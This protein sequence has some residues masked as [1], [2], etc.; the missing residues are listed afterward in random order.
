MAGTDLNGVFKSVDFGNEWITSSNG[1]NA[2]TV[3]SISIDDSLIYVGTNSGV[4]ICNKYLESWVLHNEGKLLTNVNSICYN[5]SI[6]IASIFY[7]ANISPKN[8]VNWVSTGCTV[9]PKSF[10]MLDNNI[11]AAGT[12]GISLSNNNGSSWT[13][14]NNGITNPF[15]NSITTDGLNLFAGATLYASAGIFS[16][17]MFRSID[18]GNTW[19]NVSCGYDTVINSVAINVDKLYAG[20]KKYGVSISSDYGDSWHHSNDISIQDNPITDFAFHDSIVFISTEKNGVYMSNDYGNTWIS[21]NNGLVPA[22]ILSLESGSGTLYAG[23]D[24]AGVW[25]CSIYELLDINS[26]LLDKIKIYPNPVSEIL[27]I[28]TPETSTL[29]IINIQGQIVSTKTISDKTGSIDVSELRSGVYTLRIKT[30]NGIMMKK[31]IKQ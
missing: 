8:N 17:T 5:D 13:T 21:I 12:M 19:T 22:K 30:D 20:M 11:Y 6:I 14:I 28:E 23:S 3:N 16:G 29:E 27:N 18:F 7:G 15:I 2:V 24:K 31:I 9:L 25:K 26:Y 1:I 4:Y 10:A